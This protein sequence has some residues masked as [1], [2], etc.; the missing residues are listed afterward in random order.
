MPWKNYPVTPPEI[1]PTT[2]SQAINRVTSGGNV[3]MGKPE[4]SVANNIEILLYPDC[5]GNR[6]SRNIVTLLKR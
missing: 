6:I 1:D 3:A 4:D 2:S 5:G